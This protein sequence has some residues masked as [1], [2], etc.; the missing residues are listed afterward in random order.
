[1][2]TPPNPQSELARAYAVLK[3]APGSSDREIKRRYRQ[4]VRKWHPDKYVDDPVGRGEAQL[5]LRRINDAFAMIEASFEH[6]DRGGPGTP[7][8]GL[9]PGWKNPARDDKQSQWVPSTSALQPV[10]DLLSWLLPLGAG[11]VVLQGHGND[12][13]FTA[14]MPSRA[15]RLIGAVCFAISALALARYIKTRLK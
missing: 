8:A 6:F 11:V 2:A 13:L 15:E 1:M 10:F 7:K 5:N 9:L 3:I 4:L 12:F 14:Q